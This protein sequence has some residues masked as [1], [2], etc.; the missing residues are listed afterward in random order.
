MSVNPSLQIVI[1]VTQD[2]L[3]IHSTFNQCW[4]QTFRHFSGGH[5]NPRALVAAQQKLASRWQCWS[6]EKQSQHLK[7]LVTLSFDIGQ[8]IA[9][10]VSSNK[11][12][13]AKTFYKSY[14]AFSSGVAAPLWDRQWARWGR[15]NL[16]Y[17]ESPAQ[18]EEGGGSIPDHLWPWSI[19]LGW[20]GS[21]SQIKISFE[22]I[23][24]E[25]ISIMKIIHWR[26]SWR[27]EQQPVWIV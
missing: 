2:P 19:T 11:D 18:G 9:F 7:G 20:K 3:S 17:F 10:C 5:I 8:Y 27:R 24:N 4:S 21:L 23:A 1:Q 14:F 25:I 6:Y 16:K 15:R 13:I 12:C 22:S 26:W